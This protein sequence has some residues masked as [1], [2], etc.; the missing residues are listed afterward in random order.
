[1]VMV[2]S[3]GSVPIAAMAVDN[4]S[5]KVLSSASSL[6]LTPAFST[7]SVAPETLNASGTVTLPSHHSSLSMLTPL[8]L[9][10]L[11]LHSAMFCN[12]SLSSSEYHPLPSLHSPKPQH[13]LKTSL[14]LLSGLLI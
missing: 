13:T 4:T 10:Y 7:R 12:Y 8:A 9:C 14:L 2:V 1:M 5:P 11:C 6:A 3:A